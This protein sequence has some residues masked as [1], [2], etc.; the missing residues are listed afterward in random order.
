M[1]SVTVSD[2]QVSADEHAVT[3]SIPAEKYSEICVTLGCKPGEVAQ[4]L[5]QRVSD[6]TDARIYG[7]I[8][9]YLREVKAAGKLATL[10]G[11]LAD[12]GSWADL[13][14]A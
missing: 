12:G 7:E 4:T 1:S 9:G 3:A 2:T 6:E 5:L 8:L 14:K 11:M 10:A 13:R